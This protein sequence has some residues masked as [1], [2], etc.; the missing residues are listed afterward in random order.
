MLAEA[1]PICESAVCQDIDACAERYLKRHEAAQLKRREDR[2]LALRSV[3]RWTV[4]AAA[5]AAGL[6]LL[7]FSWRACDRAEAERF[8]KARENWNNWSAAFLGGRK[9]VCTEAE[10]RVRP[11][12]TNESYACIVGT[13]GRFNERIVCFA[14]GCERN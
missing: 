13:D 2:K 6:A 5:V 4:K 3:G 14:D 11:P 8:R 12:A 7:S 10:S 1:C 9:A